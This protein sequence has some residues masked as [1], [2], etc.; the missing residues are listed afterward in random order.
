MQRSSWQSRPSST[1]LSMA[2]AGAVPSEADLDRLRSRLH[3]SGAIVSSRSVASRADANFDLEVVNVGDG[4]RATPVEHLFAR[5]EQHG[6][7]RRLATEDDAAAYAVDVAARSDTEDNTEDEGDDRHASGENDTEALRTLSPCSSGR[8]AL[9]SPAPSEA[10]ETREAYY[11]LCVPCELRLT[12]ISRRPPRW[13]ALEDV[14]FHFSSA[15]HRATASW[16]ADDD[17]D[18]TLQSTPLITPTHYYSRIYVNGIPTLLS[19]RPGGGDMFYPLPHEQDLVPAS[20]AAAPRDCDHD[21]GWHFP[22]TG[23]HS[24]EA[25]GAPAGRFF[26]P[27]TLR[28]AQGGA[29]VFWHRALPSIDT[30]TVQVVHRTRS[31]SLA[32]LPADRR[33]YRVARTR[34]RAMVGVYHCSLDEYREHS[35]MPQH[36][37][38]MS[39]AMYRL[40]RER[41]PKPLLVR[42]EYTASQGQATPLRCSEFTVLAAQAADVGHRTVYTQPSHPIAEGSRDHHRR[43][44]TFTRAVPVPITA[45]E[46]ECYRVA[47]VS[48]E[49]AKGEDLQHS[50]TSQ[51]RSSS[52]RVAG[53]D[54]EERK[55]GVLTLEL[56][57]QHTQSTSQSWRPA[58]RSNSASNS[59]IVLASVPPSPSGRSSISRLTRSSSSDTRS[60]SLLSEHSSRSRSPTPTRKRIKREG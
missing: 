58:I 50:E 49:D 44:D 17:I 26:P 6:L 48:A 56:L 5:L 36:K 34:S 25:S 3:Q 52:V 19:R 11:Y 54:L 43:V 9:S 10:S 42:P 21:D 24:S 32:D 45:F 7:R 37:V 46:D 16:M 41:I 55:C 53:G 12:R 2:G 57:M 27:T 1:R 33:R 31:S 23:S 40:R 15:A 8:R 35:W 22:R 47:L 13:R 39:L 14:H 4:R 29:P 38:P 30:G 18:E 59:S 28:G 20:S 51:Q 60:S